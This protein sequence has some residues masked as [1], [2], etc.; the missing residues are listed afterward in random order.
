MFL[1]FLI[2]LQN[3]CLCFVLL[4]LPNST[5]FCR[6]AIWQHSLN[7]C[8]AIC[9]FTYDNYLAALPAQLSMSVGILHSYIVCQN[10][11]CW[12]ANLSNFGKY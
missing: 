6:T 2:A 9:E 10:G 4:M 12:I 8:C 1:G 3:Y 5:N 11:S 7:N